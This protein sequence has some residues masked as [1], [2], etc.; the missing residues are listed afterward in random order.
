MRCRHARQN[1]C[2]SDN[3]GGTRPQEQEYIPQGRHTGDF[4]ESRQMMQVGILG[5]ENRLMPDGNMRGRL[6]VCATKSCCWSSA[7]FSI[8]YR[9]G[10]N[11][12][13]GD[14]VGIRLIEVVRPPQINRPLR[15]F[16]S[17]SGT[18]LTVNLVLTWRAEHK[19][20]CP[21][22][23][24]RSRRDLSRLRSRLSDTGSFYTSAP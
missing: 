15:E 14:S 23:Q 4:K 13:G 19:L 2:P 20:E 11:R 12:T 16:A 8:L 10:L 1:I 22:P 6:P 5:I 17:P 9:G 21:R 3:Q 7:E 24:R 18:R